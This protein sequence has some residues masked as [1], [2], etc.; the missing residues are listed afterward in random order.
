MWRE[1]AADCRAV[2]SAGRQQPSVAPPPSPP[3]SSSSRTPLPLSPRRTS[4]EGGAAAARRALP[5]TAP[6]PADAR[7]NK[8]G[9]SSCRR[10]QISGP[11]P[12]HAASRLPSMHCGRTYGWGGGV[13]TYIRPEGWDGNLLCEVRDY[14]DWKEG[15]QNNNGSKMVL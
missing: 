13:S 3:P 1:P 7:Q 11:P 4:V 6:S 10:L 15:T 14:V 5:D 8:R 9:T 2:S 12:P